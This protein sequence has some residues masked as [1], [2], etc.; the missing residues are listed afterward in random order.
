MAAARRKKPASLG[1]KILRE[2]RGYDE[3]DDLDANISTPA[4]W[5]EDILKAQ[6]LAEGLEEDQV[7]AVWKELAGDFI[8]NHTEP[9]SVKGGHLILRVTQPAMRFHLET[10]RTELL[11]KVQARFG[12][13]RIK[14]IKFGHG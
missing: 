4:A 3:A 12:K 14:S 7:R 8:G 6:G 1:K 11:G 9:V 13:N 2:W 10:M 5:I